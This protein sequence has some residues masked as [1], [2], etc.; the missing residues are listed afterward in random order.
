MEGQ[1]RIVPVRS[2]YHVWTR[3]VGHGSIPILLLHGGPGA[4]HEYLECFSQYLP[5]DKYTLYFFDQLDSYYS[6]QPGNPELWTVEG[7]VDEVDDVRRGLNLS[8]F[9]LLGQSWGG[10][11][12]IEY[13]LKY[14]THLKGVIISNMVA[15]IDAYVEYLNTLRRQLPQDIQ[16]ALERYESMEAYQNSHY[17]ELVLQ[18]LYTKHLCRLDPWPE[19]VTRSLSR[20][21]TK[22][23]E[24]MQGPNEFVVTGTF[25][26]WNRWNDLHHIA[27]PALVIGGRYDTMDPVALEK[28]GQMIPKGYSVICEKGSHMA[29]WDDPETYYPALEEFIA[30]CETTN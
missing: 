5:L 15:S 24:Y 2:Q 7:F 11:L 20:M 12:A 29:M 10:L 19:P 4:T 18:H 16:D 13:A 8:Q 21:N 14:G 9:Y 28:M 27:I 26:D 23:Y 1:T 25:K 30:S 17:Q 22:I 6:D 3:Q